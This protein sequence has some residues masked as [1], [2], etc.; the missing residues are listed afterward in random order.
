MR[1]NLPS[2]LVCLCSLTLL[3]LTSW[4]GNR[5]MME[6]MERRLIQIN[7]DVLS[8]LDPE[9]KAFKLTAAFLTGEDQ[10]GMNYISAVRD[11]RI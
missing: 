2:L 7:E 4:A 3:T 9:S 11:G 6:H 8:A 10:F 5:E 1:P